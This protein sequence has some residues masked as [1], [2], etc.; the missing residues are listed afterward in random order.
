MNWEC[1]GWNLGAG[2]EPKDQFSVLVSSAQQDMLIPVIILGKL[3][4]AARW[5]LRSNTGEPK[6]V[7][8]ELMT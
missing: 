6:I 7:I 4:S 8:C 2:S 3:L 1:L 5:I